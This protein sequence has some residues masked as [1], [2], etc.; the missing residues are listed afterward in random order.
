MMPFADRRQAGRLLATAV[1][2]ALATGPGGSAPVVAGLPRGG[3]PVAAEVAA[4]LDAPLDVLLVRKVG[5]P[6]QPE[7]AMGAIGEGDLRVVDQRLVASLGITAEQLAGAIGPERLYL[8]WIGR[9]LRESRPPVP[10]DGRT[11][12]VVDDGFATGAT[13]AVACRAARAKGAAHVVA[14]APVGSHEA[15]QRLLDE[16]DQVVVL[17]QPRRF[18][19][20][21]RWYTDFGQI[22]EQE[23]A[24]LLVAAR[25]PQQ[26]P[27]ADPSTAAPPR[28]HRRSLEVPAGAAMLE[29]RR[30]DPPDPVGLVLLVSGSDTARHGPEQRA[31]ADLL[32]RDGWST[33]LLD[34]IVAGDRRGY[35]AEDVPA[36]AARIRCA[37]EAVAA[38]HR[39]LFLLGTGIGAAACLCLV[40]G[41]DGR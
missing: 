7:L 14:A 3:V 30:A 5:V 39:R 2:S 31:L 21:G 40:A 24:D 19:A 17:H 18:V 4:A 9:R 29:L 1:R 16:A 41:Q 32:N 28:I 6:F 34:P 20:V 11:V 37:L 36:L 13:A 23:V 27:A 38:P 35:R 26:S 22:S 8:E 10:L 25:S 12:V 15:V 33:V